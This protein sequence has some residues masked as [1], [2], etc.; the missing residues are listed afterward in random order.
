MYSIKYYLRYIKSKVLW[1]TIYDKFFI[2][3]TIKK[4]FINLKK[5]IILMKKIHINC[6]NFK[7]NI[8]K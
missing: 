1:E 6:L 8:L 4:F 5:L 7:K 3:E 2:Q